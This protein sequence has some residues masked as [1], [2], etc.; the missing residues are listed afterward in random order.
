MGSNYLRVL[1]S[2]SN[3]AIARD[4]RYGEMRR[5]SVLR[6]RSRLGCERARARLRRRVRVANG[7]LLGIW[8]RQTLRPRVQKVY[9]P[10]QL[11]EHLLVQ[12]QDIWRSIEHEGEI[13]SWPTFVTRHFSAYTD[14]AQLWA[15]AF[16]LSV[17]HDGVKICQHNTP[18]GHQFDTFSIFLYDFGVIWDHGHQN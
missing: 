7:V 5:S 9:H 16:P 15:I 17:P 8:S 3:Y 12:E 4:M 13:D 14:T 6:L 10:R 1:R 2:E 11:A 18:F